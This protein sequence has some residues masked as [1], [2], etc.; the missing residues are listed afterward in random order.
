MMM[1]HWYGRRQELDPNTKLSPGLFRRV[2]GYARRYRLQV[3]AYLLT[4]GLSALVAVVPPLLVRQL[5]NAAI[6]RHSYRLIDLIGLAAVGVALANAGL[7]LVQRYFSARIGEGLI[8]DLRTDVF[9]HI[10][11]QP[12]AFFTHSQTGALTSRMNNDVIGAQ[13]ALTGT[14]GS[15]TSNLISLVTTL[16][17]MALL[18]WRI[19]LVA[20]AV[21]PLFLLPAKRV[22]RRL[23]A[24]TRESMQLNAAMNTTM[25]ERFNVAGALLVMLFG[26]RDR[27][28]AEFSAKAAGVRDIG[29]RSAMV[30]RTFFVALGLVGA[31]GT[32]LVYWLGARLVL[33]GSLRAGDV[34][35]MAAY[36][37]QVYGPLTAL[38]NARVDVMT[39][40]VSFDRVFEVL[41][42]QSAVRDRPGAR[43][44]RRPRGRIQFE[45]VDFRYPTAEESTL[46]SLTAGGQAL[47]VEPGGLV[48]RDV[49]FTA[50]PGELI[51]LVGPSG[52]GKTTTAMLVARIDDVDAGAVRVDGEDVRDLTLESLRAAIGLVPQDPHLFHDSILANLRYAKPDATMAEIE[53]ACRAARILDLIQSLPDGFDTVVGERG[54]RLSGGEKQRLA[55]ARLLLADPAIVILDEATAHLDSESEVH[56]QAAL[57]EALAGRTSLVIAH[58]LSTIVNADRILVMDRGR[59]VE[60]GAHA[61]LL[62][63]GGLY[64]DLYATQF[65]RVAASPAPAG[66]L[67]ARP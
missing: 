23:Q 46:G 28:L 41:D 39:A 52:A 62:A 64:A 3:T 1:Y 21:L 48:L 43:E 65:G 5:L 45:H 44:L 25:N 19:T 31:V 12:L 60:Q 34:V 40:F 9:D 15:V 22:G 11:R 26:R 54:Y 37:T 6:P 7:A 35:A 14:L 13:Q 57:A 10:Q 47:D 58:R 2:W 61:A 20:V 24:I 59:V 32:A 53:A 55:I 16:A 42:F 50:E 36:V 17:A 30:G 38:T 33:S 8:Y 51:A 29:V 63:R 27:E 67:A 56:I 4:I 49:S 66:G 18:N